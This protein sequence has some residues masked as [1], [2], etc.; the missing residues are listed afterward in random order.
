MDEDRTNTSKNTPN[1]PQ[2]QHSKVENQFE[3]EHEHLVLEEATKKD[4]I[5]YANVNDWRNYHLAR[6]KSRSIIRPLTRYTEF[7]DLIFNAF[8]VRAK[9]KINKLATYDEKISSKESSKWKEVIEE[10]I[11]SLKINGTW[12]LAPK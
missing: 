9:L 10:E 12:V 5:E 2:M 8:I 4:Q 3:N 6:D 1:S 11:N 7:F